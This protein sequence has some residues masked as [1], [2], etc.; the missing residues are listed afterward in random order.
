MQWMK[1]LRLIGVVLF[2]WIL[3]KVDWKTAAASLRALKPAYLAAYVGCFGFMALL[4]VIRLRLCVKRVGGGLSFVDAYLATLEPAFVGVVTP[5]RVGEL[6]RIAHLK[7]VLTLQLSVSIVGLERIMDLAIL[8]AFGVGGSIY[9]FAPSIRAVAPVAICAGL[10][11]IYWVFR[12]F[13]RAAALL[14]RIFALLSRIQLFGNDFPGT[15]M[16]AMQQA[17]QATAFPM[18]VLGAV[19]ILLNLAQIFLLGQ[20]FGFRADKI[21]VCFA[22]I[23]ATL[24]SLLPISPSGLGTREATYIYIMA[25]Q[26]IAKEQALLFALLDAVVLGPIGVLIMLAPFW[27]SR[28]AR[29]G[30]KPDG[31]NPT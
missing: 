24:L 5:G 31:R 12:A 18:L 19:C 28:S 22:Y 27:I 6:T 16:V 20:A 2:A 29:A 11:L 25:Q 23:V 13:H 3:W 8:F 9:I 15:L 1:W 7:E 10:L 30:S 17:A 14:R 21:V 4:R 26:G